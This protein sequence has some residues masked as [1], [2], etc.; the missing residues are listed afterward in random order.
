MIDKSLLSFLGSHQERY[1]ELIFKVCP[2]CGNQRWNFQVNCEDDVYHSWC[3]GY[4]GKLSTLLQKRGIKVDKT[5]WHS[6]K[7]PKT[8]NVGKISTDDFVPLDFNQFKKFLVGRG[9]TEQ[10]VSTY[11]LLTS[12]KGI[13]KDKVI[14]PLY[15]GTKLAYFVARDAIA[16]GN[17]HQPRDI[18]RSNLLLYY[19]GTKN[20]F[21]IYIVEGPFDG[22]VLNK[23]GYS[24]CMLTCSTISNEQIEKIKKFGFEEAIV[25]LDGDIKKVILKL[26]DQLRVAGVKTKVI[27]FPGKDDPNDLYVVDKEYLAK[28]LDNPI[29]PTVLDR[30]RIALGER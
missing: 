18:S 17:Y 2:N 25:C 10:D 14:I 22:I 8:K 19:L 5:P 16:K 30:A 11:N 21:R 4:S 24:V 20:R 7:Q 3:C 29:E 15:E 13:Y 26:Y 12:N 6:S 27:L 9:L 23:L 28:L 1:G